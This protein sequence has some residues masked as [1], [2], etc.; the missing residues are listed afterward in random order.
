MSERIMIAQQ[1]IEE[2]YP[3]DTILRYL[4]IAKSTFYYKP[5]EGSLAK[6]RPRSQSTKKVDG[7]SVCNEEVI[8]Q[9]KEILSEE[10]VDYGYLK[11]THALRQDYGYIISPK[12]VYRL[13]REEKLLNK[14]TKATLTRREWVK[15]LVPKPVT[16]FHYLEFD[17][18]YIY[19]KGKRRNALLLT[20][21]DVYSRWVLGQYL[22]WQIGKRD[23]IRLFD[24]IFENYTMPDQIY[25]RNDNGSQMVAQCVQKYFE[26][27]NVVQEFTKP[28]TPEQNA[29]IESYHSIIERVICQRYEF[30]D[31][32]EGGQTFN[33]FVMFYNYRRIHSG[34]GYMSPNRYLKNQGIEIKSCE[35]NV[36]DLPIK[37]VA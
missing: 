27:R 8:T 32:T 14:P 37:R 23:V 13:M 3:R 21:I 35:W 6:G 19:I 18:K 36:L 5:S 17:I 9:I 4:E 30:S 34:L 1:Y 33:R 20:V 26:K 31:I 2:G 16:H 7:H 24:S 10:F 12:K 15:E 25:V 11:T 22:S 29:H 28:A